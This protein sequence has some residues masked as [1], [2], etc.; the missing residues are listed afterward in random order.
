MLAPET[1]RAVDEFWA[2]ELGVE[3][4]A[5]RP[6]A[7][8]VLPRGDGSRGVHAMLFG[9]AAPVA[10]VSS[11]LSA[12]SRAR[13]AAAIASAFDDP[14]AL[15]A[16]LEGEMERVI[17]PATIRY[18]DRGTFRPQPPSPSVR[19]LTLDDAPA[20]ERLRVA[21]TATEWE[22][23]GSDVREHPCAGAF[24]G[25]EIAALAGY[26]VWGGAVAHLSVVTH[27]AH[28]GRGHGAA[29]V[30]RIAAE[31]LERGL[32]P[33]YRT[34]ESNAPSIAVAARLGFEPYARSL[35]VRPRRDASTISP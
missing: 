6:P 34:L 29:A 26:E 18:A 30:S 12:S 23:G 20:I 7:P 11:A 35:A 3:P 1:V 4:A 14:A 15:V 24:A 17:G 21:C 10:T 9:A 27:P 13:I 33:Q 16:A 28:R 19:M 22:H 2:G 25:D 32:V 5:L 31:A 8:A